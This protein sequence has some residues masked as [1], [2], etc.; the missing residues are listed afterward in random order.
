M[1]SRN[2][3]P[4]SDIM[5]SGVEDPLII[6]QSRL[7]ARKA[8]LSGCLASP[9]VRD[10]PRVGNGAHLL[11]KPADPPRVHSQPLTGPLRCTATSCQA[12]KFPLVA[13]F[14]IVMDKELVGQ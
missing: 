6:A 4:K 9:I 5:S 7:A 14:R 12:E 2:K 11:H 13:S 8:A 3:L 1:S 10:S